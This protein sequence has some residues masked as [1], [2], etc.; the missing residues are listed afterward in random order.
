[1]ELE[2]MTLSWR[3]GP[4]NCKP[5][6]FPRGK[7]HGIENHGAFL[8]ERIMESKTTALSSR[9][10]SW[11][12]KPRRFP[13]GKDHGIENHGAFCERAGILRF[14]IGKSDFHDG[15]QVL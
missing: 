2:T 15:V 5:R 14:L 3:K 1:M 7:D 9:K 10:G 12:R 6:R 8:Q 4:W 13:P 11:N